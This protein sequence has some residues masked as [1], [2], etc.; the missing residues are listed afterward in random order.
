MQDIWYASPKRV[1][2]HKLRAIAL[3][4][5]CVLERPKSSTEHHSQSTASTI[6]QSQQS[7]HTRS[8]MH[9]HI[10]PEHVCTLG[11]R[12]SLYTSEDKG[13]QNKWKKNKLSSLVVWMRNVPPGIWCLNTWPPGGGAVWGGYGNFRK[14]SLV[15]G[16][17][18]LCVG[19]ECSQPHP[20]SSSLS[21]SYVMHS[22]LFQPLV[23]MPTCHY[24]PS[25]WQQWSK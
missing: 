18:C 25:L 17:T 4:F 24:G 2:T 8:T 12:R 11:N 9:V 5:I 23:A 20:T 16:S 22:F 3:A 7:H 6:P 1:I 15:G 14:W 10:A 19:I 21:A 13:C